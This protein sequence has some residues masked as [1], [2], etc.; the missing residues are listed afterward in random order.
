MGL[1]MNL[2]QI[3]AE[4]ERMRQQIRGSGK[5]FNRSSARASA[6]CLPKLCWPACNPLWTSYVAS[7]TSS[8]V[9]SG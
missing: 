5:K 3:R 2:E 1:T 7:E 9:N 6:R 4:I 8:S